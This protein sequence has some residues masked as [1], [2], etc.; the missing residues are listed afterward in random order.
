MDLLVEQ[1][2]R[3]GAADERRRDV[4]EERR[5]HEDEHQQDEGP[6]PVVGEVARQHLRD[7]AL[8]EVPRQQGEAEEQAEQIEDH[9]PL[10]P[11]VGDEA[12][13]TGCPP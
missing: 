9:H 13:E 11:E 12:G 8:L 10:V 6:L 2:V 1:G 7:L 5:Q 4:V 3:H